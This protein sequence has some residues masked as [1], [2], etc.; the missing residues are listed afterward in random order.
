MLYHRLPPLLCRAVNVKLRFC[1]CVT[2]G[3]YE[4]VI[5]WYSVLTAARRRWT[6]TTIIESVV[7]DRCT[8]PSSSVSRRWRRQ[9]RPPSQDSHPRSTCIRQSVCRAALMIAATT[10]RRRHQH[11]PTN[12]WRPR[13]RRV[14][15]CSRAIASVPMMSPFSSALLCSD[16][17]PFQSI[18][19]W[20]LRWRRRQWNTAP[21]ALLESTSG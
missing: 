19:R 15:R 8:R 5:D 20:Y 4:S 1:S 13:R 17:R 10:G 2:T 21:R 3:I 14:L 6:W 7:C 12:S 9:R 16:A 11:R 18:Y